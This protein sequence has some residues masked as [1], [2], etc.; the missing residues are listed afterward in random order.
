MTVQPF[1]A[2]KPEVTIIPNMW[3]A[4]LE[5]S[6][7]KS[8]K[9]HAF[10]RLNEDLVFWLDRTGKIVVMRDMCPHR[11]AKL[12]TGAL[13]QRDIC[14]YANAAGTGRTQPAYT[15]LECTKEENAHVN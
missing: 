9:P 4:V 10:K 7:V 3:Y 8:G 11:Q 13:S 14:R 2:C 12:S 5:S 6:D 15:A 1:T